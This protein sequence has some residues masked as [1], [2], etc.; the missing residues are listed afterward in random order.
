[1]N[2]EAIKQKNHKNI[3]IVLCL[4][5]ICINFFCVYYFIGN[6]RLI[7]HYEE[8]NQN[9]L[10]KIGVLRD[11]LDQEKNKDLI[12]VKTIDSLNEKIKIQD[13]NIQA[14]KWKYEHQKNNIIH[15]NADQ[16]IDFLSKRLSEETGR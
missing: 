10:A 8:A 11:S 16:S 5:S 13:K 2:E 14:I 9:S 12:I 1:M 7:N 4:I 15:L 3:Y 6:E